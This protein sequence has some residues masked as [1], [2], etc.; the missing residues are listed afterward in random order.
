MGALG[1]SSVFRGPGKLIR[2]L[3]PRLGRSVAVLLAL[4]SPH[5][6]FRG[7]AG[8]Q[9]GGTRAKSPSSHGAPLLPPE[10]HRRSGFR[11]SAER[12][13]LNIFILFTL[14]PRIAVPLRPAAPRPL[15]SFVVGP[16][17]KKIPPPPPPPPP[18]K[19]DFFYRR[20]W[21]LFGSAAADSAPL[22][23]T[24][25]CRGCR[26]ALRPGAAG[27]EPWRDGTGGWEP[28]NP[29]S[30]VVPASLSCH[31]GSEFAPKSF[32]GMELWSRVLKRENWGWLLRGETVCAKAVEGVFGRSSPKKRTTKLK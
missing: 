18:D 3:H 26:A 22:G 1:P 23:N 27:G 6:R 2:S 5:C 12:S 8:L 9:R 25:G 7:A 17:Q 30:S 16:L 24:A 29:S 32:L 28:K 13:E 10:C 4:S 15:P 20:R 31:G 21:A 11:P 19:S 14:R